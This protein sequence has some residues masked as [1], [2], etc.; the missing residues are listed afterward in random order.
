MFVRYGQDPH[1]FGMPT[2]DGGSVKVGLWPQDGELPDGDPDRLDRTVAPESL[3]P[4]NAAVARFLPD[5][6]PTPV[7]ISAYLDAY[8]RDDHG[9]VGRMPGRD[10]LVVLGGFSGHGFKLA[11]V[12]GELAAGLITGTEPAF[13]LTHLAPGR[14]R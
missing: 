12:I 9:L 13:D 11:P 10:N 4:T 2:L 1:V 7:R 14:F 8:S 3:A 5:L 6:I